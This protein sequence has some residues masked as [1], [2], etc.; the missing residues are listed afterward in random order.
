MVSS[1]D[2]CS[3]LGLSLTGSTVL[4]SGSYT[5]CPSYCQ[6]TENYRPL[7]RLTSHKDNKVNVGGLK[8]GIWTPSK[9]TQRTPLESDDPCPFVSLPV[10]TLTSTLTLILVRLKLRL[11]LNEWN[12]LK[13]VVLSRGIVEVRVLWGVGSI[14]SSNFNK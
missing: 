2:L 7:A 14:H 6:S 13:S 11:I 5:Y 9:D 12:A 8:T 10:A 3:D 4:D 1:T